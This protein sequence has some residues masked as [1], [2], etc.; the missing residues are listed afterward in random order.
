VWQNELAGKF[1]HD[2]TG[3]ESDET[4]NM[5]ESEEMTEGDGLSYN[6]LAWKSD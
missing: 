3:L 1:F 4:T 5:G 2:S 6:I